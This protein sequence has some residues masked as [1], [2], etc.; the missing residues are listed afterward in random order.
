M[1][2][3]HITK[4][5]LKKALKIARSAK[6]RLFSHRSPSVAEGFS[7]LV[8]KHIRLRTPLSTFDYAQ[9]GRSRMCSVESVAE[10]F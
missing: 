10:R 7:I 8:S 2:L 3:T 1:N 4:K 9:W 6:E 5:P